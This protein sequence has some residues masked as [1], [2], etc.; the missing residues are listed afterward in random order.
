M[1]KDRDT[2]LRKTS[3]LQNRLA[4]IKV[5]D[6]QNEQFKKSEMQEIKNID[7]LYRKKKGIF[8]SEDLEQ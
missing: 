2:K 7:K 8:S 6:E 5:Y 3:D 4:L 1:W